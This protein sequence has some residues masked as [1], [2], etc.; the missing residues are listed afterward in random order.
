MKTAEEL[1]NKYKSDIEDSDFGNIYMLYQSSF[2]DAL[3]E[4]NKELAEKIMEM[5][6]NAEDNPHS[7]ENSEHIGYKQ[8][9]T[10]VLDMLN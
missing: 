10:E 5:I 9:L 6:E 4:H 1:W 7:I 3:A 8:A 2:Y